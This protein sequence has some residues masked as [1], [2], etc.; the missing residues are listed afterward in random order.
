MGRTLRTV[1]LARATACLA[2]Y[3]AGMPEH[4]VIDVD[5]HVFEPDGLWEQYLPTRFHGRRPRLITD[6]RGTT[7]YVVENKVIPPSTGPGAWAPEG[8]R[9]STTHREGGVD[10]A[11]RMGVST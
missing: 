6:D 5:D 4:L 11:L 3:L 7:R 2:G 9:E 10:S 8:I 1:H